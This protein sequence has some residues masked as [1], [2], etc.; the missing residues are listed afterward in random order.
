MPLVPQITLQDFDKWAVDFVSP[1]S[2]PGKRTVVRYII[3]AT[4]YMTRWEEEASVKDCTAAIAA[5]FL[6]EN[7]VTRFGF[8]NIL[9]SDQGTHFVNKLI[10]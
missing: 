5:K 9:I 1:I 10:V 3:I 6:F 7:V 2:P 4:D 8:P